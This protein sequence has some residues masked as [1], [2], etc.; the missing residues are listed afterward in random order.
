[1]IPIDID[2]LGEVSLFTQPG[3]CRIMCLN[4]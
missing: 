4:I 2:S 3:K 1:M